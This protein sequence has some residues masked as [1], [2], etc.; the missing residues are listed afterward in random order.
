[1]RE[2]ARVRDCDG[3]CDHSGCVCLCVCTCFPMLVMPKLNLEDLSRDQIQWTNPEASSAR[4]PAVSSSAIGNQVCAPIRSLTPVVCMTKEMKKL[5]SSSA[6]KKI[7]PAEEKDGSTR[8]GRWRGC[9]SWSPGS[10]FGTCCL[11]EVGA[12]APVSERGPR[13][14]GCWGP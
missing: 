1:M 12:R 4:F 5:H 7:L 10:Y 6:Y 8:N 9:P 13:G 3:T 14:S 11:D 2:S